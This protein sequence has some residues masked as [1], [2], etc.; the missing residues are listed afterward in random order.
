[1]VDVADFEVKVAEASKR[2]FVATL[3]FVE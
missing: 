2:W 1:V 3:G